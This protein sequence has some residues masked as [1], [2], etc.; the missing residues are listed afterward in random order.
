MNRL[1]RF[2]NKI[3]NVFVWLPIIWNDHDWDH[4]YFYIIIRHKLKRMEKFFRGPNAL[5]LGSKKQANKIH[6]CVLVLDRLIED[7]YYRL[8]G[9][10]LFDK[11]W[12]ALR[13][14]TAPI[15]KKGFVRLLLHRENIITLEDSINSDREFKSILKKKDALIKQDLVYLFNQLQKHITFWWD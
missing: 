13:M 7:D 12:G 5:C 10:E 9:M 1:R 11:K 14:E 4:V 15:N 6:K 2:I 3:I 8:A